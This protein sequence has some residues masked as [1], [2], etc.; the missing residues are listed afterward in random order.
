[1]MSQGDVE[2][3]P[4][5]SVGE[6]VWGWRWDPQLVSCLKV[7]KSMFQVACKGSHLLPGACFR[8]SGLGWVDA[9]APG[10]TPLHT[11]GQ[12]CGWL[13]LKGQAL[14]SPG[15]ATTERDRRGQMGP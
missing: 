8:G 13:L 12:A 11:N 1:M 9:R 2:R 7:Q 3:Q 15:S 5:P 4:Q 14:V 10:S 6:G